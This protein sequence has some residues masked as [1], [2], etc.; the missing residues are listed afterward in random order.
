MHKMT[1]TQNN[2]LRMQLYEENSAIMHKDTAQKLGINDG[3]EVT[4]ESR[5]GEIKLKAQLIEGI[6]PDCVCVEHGLDTG[7]RN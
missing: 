4:V 6:R 3:D 7:P 2:E 5:V 1:A